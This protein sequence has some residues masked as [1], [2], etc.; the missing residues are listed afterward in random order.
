LY[1]LEQELPR[2]ANYFA[3]EIADRI[4]VPL[5]KLNSSEI[6][7]ILEEQHLNASL[8]AIMVVNQFDDV[9]GKWQSLLSNEVPVTT[10]TKP[11]YWKN[12]LI[13]YVHVHWSLQP[14]QTLRKSLWPTILGITG[15][16]IMVQFF[17]TLFLTRRF[18]RRPLEKV[19][20]SMQNTAQGKYD[21]PLPTAR[22]Q[23]IR[24]L[25]EEA[26]ELA[27]RIRE[28]TQALKAEINKRLEIA[29]ELMQHRNNLENLVY[30][31]TQELNDA[32]QLL[33]REMEQ[34]K[35][36]QKSII[37]ISTH[38]QQRIGQNLHDTLGQEI[39]GAR[40]LLSSIE[41]AMGGTTPEYRDRLQQLS[42]ILRDVMEHA[43]MLAH[44]LMV[45]DL[46]EGGLAAAL[47]NYTRKTASLF[48]VKCRFRLHPD[49][50]PALDQTTSV[51]LYY[52]AQEA[53]NNAIRHG[54]A[55]RIRITLASRMG[56][57][58]LLIT[59][60]GTGFNDPNDG[61]TGLIIM[62]S[63]AESIGGTITVWSRLGTGSC[64][65]CRFPKV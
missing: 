29:A 53:V 43:R 64:I 44:G 31:R 17:L 4:R 22:H 49:A 63:R 62:R 32:N 9:L 46:K 48:H 45:V 59:D 51:Q 50:L 30:I 12:E 58:S 11:V 55:T 3:D 42:T 7:D 18:L 26:N 40:Y 27:N 10:V 20:R 41:R 52:I 57:P 1:P 54:Q 24:Q 65:L 37:R 38:E 8:T 6:Q 13:G 19:I 47:E 56:T 60:N 23:E 16:G 36:A 35:I 2:Q 34:R 61:G 14:I 28:R 39:V 15:A 25:H 5:W 33:R 21:L